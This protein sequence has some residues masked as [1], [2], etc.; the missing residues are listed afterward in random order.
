VILHS[1]LVVHCDAIEHFNHRALVHGESHYFKVDK[2]LKHP[3]GGGVLGNFT[4]VETF[5]ARNTHWVTARIDARDPNVF[6]FE[7]RIVPAN[8]Q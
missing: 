1:L 4:R 2:P 6:V 8:A 3:S 5:G 7:P